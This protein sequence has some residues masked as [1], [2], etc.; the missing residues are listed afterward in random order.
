MK[1][2]RVPWICCR[3]DEIDAIQC[4][5]EWRGRVFAVMAYSDREAHAWWRDVPEVQRNE[6]LGLSGTS[7]DGELSLF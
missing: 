5:M 7:S 2:I 4:E 1:L 3:A 6:L